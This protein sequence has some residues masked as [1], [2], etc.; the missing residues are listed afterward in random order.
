MTVIK[1]ISKDNSKTISFDDNLILPVIFGEHDKY[2]KVI[3]TEL[4]VQILPRG[5]FLK[6]LGKV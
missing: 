3:E 1:K 5:N 4:E 6:I 2:L